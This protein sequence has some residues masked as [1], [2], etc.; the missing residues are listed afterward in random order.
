MSE[1]IV[2]Q[3]VKA[4]R[5]YSAGE[6]A[7]FDADVVDGLKAKGFAE[8]YEKSGAATSKAKPT[9]AASVKAGATKASEKTG[10]GSSLENGAGAPPTDG[11]GPA[12]GAENG[13]SGAGSDSGD[14]D[15]NE[16]P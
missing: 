10:T 7:G 3:F 8:V 2:V 16:K 1:K 4:W 9:K 11:A 14:D 15:D 6:L 13:S 5:G 12:S